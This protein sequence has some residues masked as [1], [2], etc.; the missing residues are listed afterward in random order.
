MGDDAANGNDHV[1][2]DGLELPEGV[3][4]FAATNAKEQVFLEYPQQLF[5]ETKRGCPRKHPVLSHGPISVHDI[6]K[7]PALPWETIVLAERAKNPIIAERKFLRC[8]SICA[9]RSRNYVKQGEE[10]WLY[11]RRYAGD[12]TKLFVCNTVN[13]NPCA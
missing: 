3:W 12:E 11:L 13:V 5:P 10:I 4:Y 7:D 9:D 8:F 6:A 1:F 2:L